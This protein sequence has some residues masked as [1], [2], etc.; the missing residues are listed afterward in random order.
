MQSLT[1]S[2]VS[3]ALAVREGSTDYN[4]KNQPRKALIEQ[5]CCPFIILERS[6][7]GNAADL[8]LRFFYKSIRDL[9]VQDPELLS[10]RD[11]SKIFL[12]TPEQGSIHMAQLCIRYLSNDRYIE[13]FDLKALVKDQVEEHWL[14]RYS[15]HFWHIHA[16]FAPYSTEMLEIVDGFVRS[17]QFWNCMRTQA[18]VGRL[19]S[20]DYTKY[21]MWI[22]QNPDCHVEEL[23]VVPLLG[24]FD[25]CDTDLFIRQSFTAF[26]KEW[27]SIL[28]RH[29]AAALKCHPLTAGR[30]TIFSL[31][32]LLS[33]G[34][35][36]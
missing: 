4:A 23:F 24:W 28:L 15:A 1:L 10:I 6:G 30:G 17:P 29:P 21:S 5:L 19:E 20:S 13:P 22:H 9:F 31:E 18:Q 33:E 34:F 25:Q 14:L 2:E 16:D 35:G 27:G 8:V 3:D 11:E 26:V 12:A 36:D 7:K 32:P